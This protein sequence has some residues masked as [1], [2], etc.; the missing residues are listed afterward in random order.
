MGLAHLHR[1]GFAVA[2]ANGLATLL[3]AEDET[4]LTAGVVLE[5]MDARERY[6]FIAGITEGLAAARYAAERP[7]TDG[8]ACIYQWFY[9]EEETM[10]RIV[11]AFEHFA[12]RLPGEIVLAMI[13]RRCP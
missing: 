9:G 11:H 8:R 6:T 10:G 7:A 4:V 2:I 1:M 12:D 5:R 13:Q 3:S